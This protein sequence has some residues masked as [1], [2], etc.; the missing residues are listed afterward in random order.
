M[1]QLIK[2]VEFTQKLIPVTVSYLRSE[3]PNVVGKGYMLPIYNNDNF[4]AKEYY[5]PQYIA[6]LLF[7]WIA[8]NQYTK[9]FSDYR[10]EQKGI[11]IHT[12]YMTVNEYE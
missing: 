4:P 10:I 3:C 7:D 2:G 5:I 9:V 12:F 6:N 11:I 1:D 8:K